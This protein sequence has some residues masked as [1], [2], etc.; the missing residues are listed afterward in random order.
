MYKCNICEKEFEN[1]YAFLGHCSSHNRKKK[2]KKVKVVVEKK[3][4]CKFCDKEFSTGQKLGSHVRMCKLNPNY[5]ER[6]KKSSEKSKITKDSKWHEKYDK[7]V[8]ESIM[9]KVENGTWHTS[10]KRTRIYEYNGVKLHGTWELEYAK[11]LDENNIKWRRPIEKFPYYFDGKN[12]HYT[13]DFYLINTKEYIEIKGYETDKDKAKWNQFPE[14][15][16]ILK[17]KEL[18]K[19]RLK[20]K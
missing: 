8:S 9:K 17:S 2:E 10:F 3:Y 11:W 4:I 12:R 15:L 1:R 14:K 18:K 13:P 16:I 5:S 6:I 19:L 7:L 20:I